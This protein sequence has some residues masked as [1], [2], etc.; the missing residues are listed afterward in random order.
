MCTR[1]STRTL[2]QEPAFNS[3]IMKVLKPETVTL[4]K[5]SS[6]GKIQ[7]WTIQVVKNM[8]CTT[9]GFKGGAMTTSAWT[10][11]KGKNTGRANATTDA[12]QAAKEALSKVDKKLK[13]GWS[14]ALDSVDKDAK[15]ISPMLAKNYTDYIDKVEEWDLVCV[16][17]KLDG[18]RCIGTREGLFS[19]Q[20]NKITSAPHIEEEV[21]RV[22]ERRKEIDC[23]DGELYNHK[24]KDDFNEIASL[25]RR[26]NLSQEHLDLSKKLVQ[27][28]VYDVET[29][30]IFSN[31]CSLVLNILKPEQVKYLIPVETYILGHK[32]K[33]GQAK[34]EKW[35]DEGYEGMMYRDG[36]A[37]YI[38]KRTDSLLKRKEW[39]E[40]EFTLLDIV[41]GRGN[42]A[43]MAATA[44]CSTEKGET[45]EAGI[46][47]SEAYCKD[48]L[49]DKNR[50]INKVRAT[51]KYQNLTP[52]RQVPRFP[53][54]KV[55]RDYE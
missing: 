12:E 19:R 4:Y 5:R 14:T 35:L 43:G 25:V 49:K 39:Q 33:T 15:K 7:S 38:N 2:V 1:A 18:I 45:F 36:D 26:E 48:L 29:D 44:V 53:K 46:I 11:A 22:L 8:Y 47:G 13:S 20:G 50:Y 10:F 41:E 3:N 21:L 23:L 24:L 27:Y 54:M 34:Y 28:H 30:D 32:D 40:E 9:E 16:Q 6:S 52:D 51:I 42:R 37:R 17:P 31:R 55:L